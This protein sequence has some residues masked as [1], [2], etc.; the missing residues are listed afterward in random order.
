MVQVDKFSSFCKIFK[1]ACRYI[2]KSIIL[3]TYAFT[4]KIMFINKINVLIYI[5]KYNRNEYII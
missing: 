5:L 1:K 4:H 3:Y 2:S